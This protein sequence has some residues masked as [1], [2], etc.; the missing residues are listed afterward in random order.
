MS[1]DQPAGIETLPNHTRVHLL[2]AAGNVDERKLSAD[3]RNALA[4]L[5]RRQLAAV[6]LVVQAAVMETCRVFLES[7]AAPA[8]DEPTAPTPGHPAGCSCGECAYRAT[9]TEGETDV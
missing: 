8:E 9:E 5:D 3:Q 4:R 7:T 6:E 1:A 2:L